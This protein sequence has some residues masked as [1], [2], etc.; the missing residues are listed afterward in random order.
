MRPSHW[1]PN[2]RSTTPDTSTGVWPLRM[3]I[4]SRRVASAR[5]DPLTGTTLVIQPPFQLTVRTAQLRQY[6]AETTLLVRFGAVANAIL[7]IGRAFRGADKSLGHIRDQVWTASRVSGAA[8]THPATVGCIARGLPTAI[9]RWARSARRYSP[10]RS[11]GRG[12]ES[13]ASCW[14]ARTF[15][16]LPW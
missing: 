7:S 13:S 2:L 16:S 14:L 6:G 8:S 15:I 9:R 11:R 4:S 12:G 1:Q 10:T 5:P 3:P